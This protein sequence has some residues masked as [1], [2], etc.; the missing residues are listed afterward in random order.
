MNPAVQ[1]QRGFTLV[2]L[3]VTL[4]VLAILVTVAVPSFQGSIRLNR[5]STCNN[6]MLAA[7]NLARSEAIKTRGFADV[8]A[9]ADGIA[10]GTDWTQGW[11]VWV[12]SNRDGVLGLPADTVLRVEHCDAQI[13]ATAG[14][15]G[16][17]SVRF[18]GRGLP[19]LPAGTVF[20]ANVISLQP[21]VCEPGVEH[22]RAIQVARTG[23]VRTA[24]GTC[25]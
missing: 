17:A 14:I 5:V 7:L 1:P 13:V 9:S 18:N 10:C 16:P 23:Q 8:C 25:P 11:M 15:A 3:M 19:V 2:E 20:P 4:A 22:V 12:D 24:K 21:A 6:S